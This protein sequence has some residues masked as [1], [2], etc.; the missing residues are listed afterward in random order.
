MKRR[1]VRLALLQ[2]L[3]PTSVARF[4]FG[5]RSGVS[6]SRL[7]QQLSAGR[8]IVREE[9]PIRSHPA[10]LPPYPFPETVSLRNRPFTPRKGPVMSKKS[11]FV[12]SA[13]APFGAKGVGR[14][15]GSSIAI[16][17]IED[18]LD[19]LVVRARTSRFCSDCGSA[20]RHI[21]AT[22]FICEN[23]RKWSV[24]LPVCPRCDETPR[25]REIASREATQG[26][27]TA[28]LLDNEN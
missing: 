13:K 17:E 5:H 20:V 27:R 7:C 19:A 10:N 23:G 6:D 3:T 9:H 2:G 11:V 4:S 22:F 16:R 1:G 28:N 21:G 14:T 18:T 25:G 8:D 24:L 26:T 12:P 15:L